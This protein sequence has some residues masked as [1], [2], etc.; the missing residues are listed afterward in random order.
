MGFKDF[1]RPLFISHLFKPPKKG[2]S[3]FGGPRNTRR[4]GKVCVFIK[5]QPTGRRCGDVTTVLEKNAVLKQL[6]CNWASHQR[7]GD[8]LTW[9]TAHSTRGTRTLNGTLRVEE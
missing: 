7:L 1:A 4:G 3:N 9:L 5:E 6:L 2:A 8:T